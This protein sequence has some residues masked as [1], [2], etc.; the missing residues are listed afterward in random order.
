MNLLGYFAPLIDECE[1]PQILGQLGVEKTREISTC[2][3][4]EEYLRMGEASFNLVL[5]PEARFAAQD[6]NQRIAIPY[7][8]LFRLY[9]LDKIQ[10]QYHL[11]A[12]ALGGKISDQDWYDKT[13]QQIQKFCSKYP[14]LKVS[15]G[16]TLNANAFELAVALI[17]YGFQ[18]KE[19]FAN[20]GEEDYVYLRKIA[21]L[22][23]DTRIYSNLE[24]T[25]LYYD[26]SS[27]DV[28]LTIGKDAKWYHPDKPNLPWNQDK[29]PFGYGGLQLLFTQLTRLLE[30][31]HH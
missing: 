31:N 25:M 24:P 6:M 3:D 18:V 9:Q 23:P 11:F 19:I 15:I 22:S 1:L 21:E 27:E 10:N 20:L 30:E 2:R 17:R 5:N 7:A 16:G 28:D 26:C 14:E 13:S 12:K 8:E 4:Y 29:Q